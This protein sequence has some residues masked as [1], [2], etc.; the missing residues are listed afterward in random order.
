MPTGRQASKDLWFA[1]ALMV[2]ISLL[3]PQGKQWRRP[4]VYLL[5]ATALSTAAVGLLKR[6]TNMDCPWDLLRYGGDKVYYGV[7]HASAFDTGPCEVF[8]RRP[9]QRRLRLDRAVLLLPEHA[10][11]LALVGAWASHWVWA[12]CSGSRNS[13]AARTSFP[14]TSGR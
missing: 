14:M 3:V 4:L 9:C 7:I 10:S 13:F 1:L 11:A 6:W 2:A 12:P 8:S 5:L